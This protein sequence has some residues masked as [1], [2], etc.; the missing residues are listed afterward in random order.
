MV[1][2]WTFLIAVKYM[3]LFQQQRRLLLERWV[4]MK[5]KIK[6]LVVQSSVILKGICYLKETHEATC[7]IKSQ[8]VKNLIV[9]MLRT[10]GFVCSFVEQ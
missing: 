6:L 7:S 3:I 1:Q 5:P 8:I 9:T 10:K 2:E 4:S